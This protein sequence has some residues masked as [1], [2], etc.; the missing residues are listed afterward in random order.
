M[1]WFWNMTSE[2]KRLA[3]LV[4]ALL[5][6]GGLLYF[7][8]DAQTG[9]S[10]KAEITNLGDVSI[11][12]DAMYYRAKEITD[13][14]GFIN[15][16]GDP[17]KISDY[18]GKK[19]VLVDFWTYSCINC[20]RTQPYLNAWYD[21]Y[22]DD[23]FVIVGVHTPEFEFEKI[24]DNVLQATKD[25][26]IKYPVVLDNNYGTWRA[27]QNS[28]WPRK[29]LIDIDGYIVYDHIGEGAYDE[30]EL[31]IQEALSERATRLGEG[32]DMTEGLVAVDGESITDSM[33]R[34]PEIYFG[35]FRNSDYLGNGQSGISGLQNF[36]LPKSLQTS[37]LY[38]DGPWTITESIYCGKLKIRR[39]HESACRW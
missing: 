36:I 4:S 1:W 11:I 3:M 9:V 18:I 27:Y 5:V 10:K 6:I 22:K 17:I 37:S 12:K 30:T 25:E 35:A 28:Y 8:S 2:Q 15:T 23:G 13:P 24:Y 33:P 16:G 19:V 32:V 26:G 31:K 34:T 39:K 20:I 7:L 29:Y 21:K 14:Q 38:F